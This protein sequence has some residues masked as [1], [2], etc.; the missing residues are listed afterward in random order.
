VKW[1]ASSLV[2]VLICAGVTTSV[3]L[4]E[5]LG[6]TQPQFDFFNRLEWITFDWR[7]REAAKH[8]PGIATNLGFVAIEDSSIEALLH[9]P[10]QFG[11][12]WPRQVYARLVDELSAEGAATIGF[13]V[14]FGELRP[15][16]P[17]VEIDGKKFSSDE[18]FAD[19][20]R[21]S[22]NVI[23]AAESGVF[24]PQ[25]F[26]TS[27]LAVAHLSAPRDHG[28]LRRAHA[29]VDV[30]VWHPAIRE[31]VRKFAWRL[32]AAEIKAREVLF[33]R[34]DA[35]QTN[36]VPLNPA[37]QF[38]AGRL[39]RA[40]AEDDKRVSAPRFEIP[41]RD[42]RLWQ[43][44]I[45]L[46]AHE[47]KLDLDHA[48]VDLVNGRI[49]FTNS[50]GLRR[51]LPIDGEGRFYIDWS[52][53]LSDPRLTKR[54]IEDLLDQ[55]EARRV[56]RM[57]EVTNTFR[58]QIVVVGSMASG[59][60]LGDYGATPLEQLTHL[61]S[62]H[63]N[64]A[65]S[66]LMN[67]FIQPLRLPWRFLIIVVMGALA[68]ICTWKMKTLSAV[69]SVFGI[70]AVYVFATGW[71][72][73]VSRLWIPIVTPVVVSELVTH[74]CLI[75]YLVRVERRERRR[76]KDI[77]SKIVSPE[78]VREL[79]DS[80]K[81]SLEGARREVTIFFA[82][83]RGFTEITDI[84]QQ[85]VEALVATYKFTS[86]E[87]EEFSNQRAE[88]V[89]R[90][91]NLYL[92]LAGDCI[93]AHNGT[94]DKYIGDCV[95]AFWG[96]PA[97]NARH[98]ASCVHAVID[99]QRAIYELNEK[100]RAENN[101][102]EEENIRRA[103]AGEMPLPMLELLTLGSGINTGVATVGLMGSDA[104]MLNYT[105][106]GRAV[107]LASRLEGASGRARILIGEATYRALLRDDPELAVTCREQPPLELKGFRDLVKT[108]EVPWHSR[109]ISVF[110]AGQTQTIV[111]DKNKRE[112]CY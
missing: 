105:V 96:A 32:D 26:S 7:V 31:A 73:N 56:G 69:G 106:F 81:L 86:E 110:D 41:F 24:P 58:N 94:L 101:Q 1:K 15:D 84:N 18:F 43:L 93:K 67:R 11:L 40:L 100:R 111:R 62:T 44:G 97:P 25:L 12:L 19:A 72:F 70:A 92:G 8:S 33:P 79:L 99:M 22:S 29:F 76:T 53:A 49:T 9:G 61:V 60:N 4:I 88:E 102:R 65:N 77:F 83:V 21:R 27:A 63:W 3:C 16:H 6:E 57:A 46:A 2:P 14:L 13:D 75:T 82:D 91:V 74:V 38:D 87:A 39:E 59:N 98:A 78:I 64:V 108:Y 90:T 50:Y 104:H 20:M 107:N 37:G 10:Y 71:V 47:L 30:R 112:D 95:M 5:W 23:L 55:Y 103:I 35:D 28:V 68:G 34:L 80:E 85:S 89:L 48:A 51:V 17:S 36:V 54:P 109:E 52:L 45:A 66:M 42:Q